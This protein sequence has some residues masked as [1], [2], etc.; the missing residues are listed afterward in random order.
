[1][2]APTETAT[3]NA[4]KMAAVDIRWK[5][6]TL[7]FSL[8]ETST[9]ADLRAAIEKQTGCLGSKV[10]LFF[11]NKNT[12]DEDLLRNV[13]QGQRGPIRMFGSP[14]T[15]VQAAV[16]KLK[17]KEL[18]ANKNAK[19]FVQYTHGDGTKE[20]VRLV[21]KHDEADGGGWTIF[22]PSLDRER[23]TTAERLDFTQG[24]NK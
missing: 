23:Q 14:E 13:L 24:Q 9:V 10:K 2:A 22:I 18:A 19:V 16:E 11:R 6:Q 12:T 4:K 3:E 5:N 7:S 21:K 15:H 20:S 1:M 8:E 17:A